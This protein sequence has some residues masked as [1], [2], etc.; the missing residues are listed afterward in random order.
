M[1]KDWPYVIF[2]NGNYWK[3]HNLFYLAISQNV[4]DVFSSFELVH[5]GKKT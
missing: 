3:T 4:Y 5:D 2:G 1:R